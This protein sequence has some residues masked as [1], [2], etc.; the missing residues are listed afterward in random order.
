MADSRKSA[1]EPEAMPAHEK[2]M[3]AYVAEVILANVCLSADRYCEQ[4]CS[5]EVVRL[6]MLMV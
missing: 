6:I 4:F 1:A 2:R 3:R 5:P